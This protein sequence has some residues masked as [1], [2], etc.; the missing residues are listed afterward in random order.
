MPAVNNT[1][2]AATLPT[3]TGNFTIH[4]EGF[5]AGASLRALRH[6]YCDVNSL[7]RFRPRRRGG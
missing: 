7:G 2:A 4:D 5:D 6:K 1:S 3:P